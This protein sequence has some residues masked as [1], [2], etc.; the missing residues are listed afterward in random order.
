MYST[1]IISFDFPPEK[2]EKNSNLVLAPT[3]SFSC[4]R[5]RRRLSVCQQFIKLQI[6]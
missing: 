4:R 6:L 2:E 5:C 3:S 1:N